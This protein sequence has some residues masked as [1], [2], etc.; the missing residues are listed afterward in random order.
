MFVRASLLVVVLLTCFASVERGT[1][2][3]QQ[4]TPPLHSDCSTSG[5]DEPTGPEISIEQVTFNGPLHLSVPE[6]EAIADDVKL[7]THGTSLENVMDEA[8]ERVKNGWQDRGYF[9]VEGTGQAKTLTSDPVSRRI[10]LSLHVE[11]G[12]QYR[13][14]SIKF[15]NNK[16]ISNTEILRSAF[17]IGDGDVFSREKIGQGLEVVRKTY[18]ELGYVNF[19]SVPD[20]RIDDE[21]RLI[22]LVVDFDEGKEFRVGKIVVLGLEES[23]GQEFLD[24]FPIHPGQAFSSKVWEESL[25]K[26]YA[27]VPDCPCRMYE[28]PRFENK[29][30]LV[31]LTL[32]FRPCVPE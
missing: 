21:S 19:T 20:T 12:M 30:A 14:R 18:G 3:A 24:T 9:K 6:Q 4:T 10:A 23:A 27:K 26:Y 7:N 16:A 15:R 5:A 31:T 32:D 28:G 22:S 29:T 13:L 8:V 11:E 25:L 1:L 2:H 17:P